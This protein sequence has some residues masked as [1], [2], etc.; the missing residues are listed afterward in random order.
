MHC[1]PHCS[2]TNAPAVRAEQQPAHCSPVQALTRRAVHAADLRGGGGGR[3]SGHQPIHR[4][5]GREAAAALGSGGGQGLQGRVAPPRHSVPPPWDGLL[6]GPRAAEPFLVSPYFVPVPGA[7]SSGACKGKATAAR[8]HTH[9]SW[10][11]GVIA[12]GAGNTAWWHDLVV[13]GWAAR[14]PQAA[15]SCSISGMV[16]PC[17]MQHGGHVVSC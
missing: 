17:G 16:H 8:N 2:A 12:R 4:P 5:G 3:Q 14:A 1:K 9:I 6:Q 15:P 10:R 11:H 7:P 13:S